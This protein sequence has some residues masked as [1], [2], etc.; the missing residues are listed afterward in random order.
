MSAV[1]TDY[2]AIQTVT[3]C[4]LT[5]VSNRRLAVRFGLAMIGKRSNLILVA[6]IISGMRIYVGLE[7]DLDGWRE[8]L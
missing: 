6:T 5:V 7:V 2:L 1:R 4:F 8:R 3:A